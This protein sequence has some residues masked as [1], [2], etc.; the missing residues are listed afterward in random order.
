MISSKSIIVLVVHR[1]SAGSNQKQHMHLARCNC[2]NMVPATKG[3]LDITSVEESRTSD[4]AKIRG[5]MV[6]IAIITSISLVPTGT[7]ES[8]PSPLRFVSQGDLHGGCCRESQR[9]PALSVELVRGPWQSTHA[10]TVRLGTQNMVG[11]IP[12]PKSCSPWVYACLH[13]YMHVHVHCER[14]RQ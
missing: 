5:I 6:T 12:K 11:F 9:H 3:I 2:S 4:V 1:R 13:V 8:L 14:L 7:I 10:V